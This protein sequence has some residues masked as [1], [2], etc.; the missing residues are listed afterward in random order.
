MSVAMSLTIF[1]VG[2]DSR[3]SGAGGFDFRLGL[4]IERVLFNHC[5]LV[6]LLCALVTGLLGW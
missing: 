6:L 3:S 1:L 5:A 2:A 4:L